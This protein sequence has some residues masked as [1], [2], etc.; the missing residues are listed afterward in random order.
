[1]VTVAEEQFGM[2]RLDDLTSLS[3]AKIRVLD[4]TGRTLLETDGFMPDWMPAW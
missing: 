1:M 2:P 3:N 4:R